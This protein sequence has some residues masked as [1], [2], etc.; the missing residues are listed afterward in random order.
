MDFLSSHEFQISLIIE[1]GILLIVAVGVIACLLYR[2][3]RLSGQ[4]AQ[5]SANAEN[6]VLAYLRTEINI[7]REKR[8]Q[9]SD[10]D[11][12]AKMRA[13]CDLRCRVL[14]G[15]IHV[16]E[17]TSTDDGHYWQPVLDYYEVIH[18]DFASQISILEARLEIC[19]QRINSLENFKEKLFHLRERLNQSHLNNS[20]LEKKLREKIAQGSHLSE[21]EHLL[22]QM[23]LEKAGLS[24]ELKLAEHEFVAIMENAAM[25]TAKILDLN[26]SLPELASIESHNAKL[27]K[28]LAS[29]TEENEFLC[30]QI[31]ALLT[32]EVEQGKKKQVKEQAFFDLEKRYAKME[33]RYLRL[34]EKIGRYQPLVH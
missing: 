2:L 23:E 25:G 31:Q 26:V 8:D 10:N 16:L 17:D 28:K 21:L 32:L 3:M 12:E 6:D 5:S 11:S 33:E 4:P 13:A 7:S 19:T 30:Q 22:S 15:E 18:A 14:E 9:L 29:I 34:Q 27:E 20:R 1:T 24:K